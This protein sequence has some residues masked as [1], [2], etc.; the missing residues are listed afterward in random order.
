[1]NLDSLDVGRLD[2]PTRAV[3]IRRDIH[4]FV[5][6]IRGRDVKRTH[7]GNMLSKADAARL[8]K[9]LSDPN[10]AKEVEEDGRSDWVDYVDRLVLDLGF[11]GYDTKGV[12]VGYTSTAPSFPEN[13]IRFDEDAY[14]RFVALSSAKQESALLARLLSRDQGRDSEFYRD[15]V[16]GRLDRFS[17]WGS[18][19][20]VMPLLDFAAARRF[21]LGVLAECPPGQWFGT[22]SL[23]EHLKEHHRYFLIPEK[24]RFR[25]QYDEQY[26][27]YGNFRESKEKWGQGTAVAESD[28]DSFQRV[29]GRY[30]ERF[31]EDIPWVMGYVDVAYAR[32]TSRRVHPSFGLLEAFRVG[33]RLGRALRE[34]I[35]E[36]RITV[37]P[38]FDIFVQAETYPVSVLARLAPLCEMVKEDA[39]FVLKLTKRKVAAARASDPELDV[40][41]LL[42]GLSENELPANV[43]RELSGWSEHGEKFV[44]YSGYSVLEGDQDLTAAASFT[45]ETLAPGVLLTH[46]PDKLF[47]E[48]ERRELMPIRVKHGD[49][50][51]TPLPRRARTRFAKQT[52]DR[53]EPS[54]RKLGVAL[55]RVTRVQLICPD[56][57]F[58]DNFLRL[59]VEVG[60]PVEANRE[61]LLLSYTTANEPK[62]SEAIRA[63]KTRYRITIEDV[64]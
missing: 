55:K 51:F 50:E 2:A 17:T 25:N 23:I 39:S 42:R 43:V 58:F 60:V 33:D 16:L 4:V 1:M 44:V 29:E 38:S 35:G 54:P 12:Y 10:A 61:H 45:V 56:Q 32:D 41:A 20:G 63:L 7:R 27:R 6:Y 14:Q 5:D 48:L 57:G 13:F 3:D 21:L 31:L 15:S 49:A 9:L 36:P 37:T 34:R 59:L 22:A 52:A 30:V 24:P 47:D 26:G 19:T 11:I 8:A 46:S 40:V 28:P 62:V 53:K 64:D 18:A